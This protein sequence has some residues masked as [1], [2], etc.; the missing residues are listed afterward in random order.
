MFDDDHTDHIHR[1]LAARIPELTPAEVVA[2]LT[3]GAFDE[4]VSSIDELAEAFQGRLDALEA[5]LLPPG[6]EPKP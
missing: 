3:D 6:N 1:L 5:K 4:I 2:A